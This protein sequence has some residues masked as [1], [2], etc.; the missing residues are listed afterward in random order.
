MVVL[1]AAGR[2]GHPP[3]TFHMTDKFWRILEQPCLVFVCSNFQVL[4]LVGVTPPPPV[5][6]AHGFWM[7]QRWFLRLE[8]Y[9]GLEGVVG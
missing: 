9:V 8:E 4:L 3:T 7:K 2:D 5:M 6:D 1:Q